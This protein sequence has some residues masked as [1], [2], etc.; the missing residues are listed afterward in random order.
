VILLRTEGLAIVRGGRLLL[1]RLDLTLA[2]GEAVHLTGPNGVGKSSLLRCLAGLLRP[3]AGRMSC[4]ARIAFADER[5]P[6]D[7]ELPLVAALAFWAAVDPQP[8]APLA[9]LA[10][11]GLEPLADVPV[12]LLSSGQRKRAALALVAMS[13]APL[14]LLDE[15]L[16]ALDQEGVRRLEGMIAAHRASGGAVIAASHLPLGGDGWRELALAP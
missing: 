10:E 11:V 13:A 14:W 3:A 7:N 9:A 16:N 8:V 6:L 4:E 12:R 15:P 5:L 1:Q 2:R